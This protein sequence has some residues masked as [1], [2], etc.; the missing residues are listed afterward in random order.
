MTWT[1]SADGGDGEVPKNRLYYLGLGTVTTVA[2]SISAGSQTVTPASMRGI[3]VGASLTAT[4]ADG[5]S[6]ETVIVSGV[7]G[8]T[9]TATF[10]N[11]H[12]AGWLVTAPLP[13]Y[14]TDRDI[15]VYWNGHLWTAQ[16]IT[17]EA[18]NNQPTGAQ[19][20]FKIDDANNVWFP[21]LMAIN[22]GELALAAI[23]EAGFAPSNR[24]S[25]PDDVEPVFAGRVDRS[26]LSTVNED[27]IEIIL[28]P[29]AQQDSAELPN[30]L[31]A[32]MVRSS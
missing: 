5:T 15:D 2:A 4:N 8:T 18:I 21:L 17:P 6:Q 25:I 16:P 20:A 28:M 11:A 19:A 9:F 3:T 27:N 7:T 12:T 30:R 29:P 32:T 13:V 24:S 10:L 31:V 23:Y 22:G 14:W 26:T 1:F